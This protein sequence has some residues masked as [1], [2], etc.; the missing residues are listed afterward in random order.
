MAM[1]VIL[2][3]NCA[4]KT[5]NWV[6]YCLGWR[7]ARRSN[8]YAIFLAEKFRL[9]EFLKLKYMRGRGLCAVNS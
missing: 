8:L 6:K 2:S 1:G 3:F 4:K 9:K 7:I 5:Q